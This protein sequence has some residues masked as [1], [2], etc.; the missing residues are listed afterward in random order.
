[1]RGPTCRE[2]GSIH[3]IV[4]SLSTAA[5]AHRAGGQWLILWRYLAASR[6]MLI[7]SPQRSRNPLRR[8][9]GHLH[10]NILNPR[11]CSFKGFGLG[12]SVLPMKSNDGVGRPRCV[13]LDE[14]PGLAFANLEHLRLLHGRDRCL[15]CLQKGLRANPSSTSSRVS[16]RKRAKAL[17]ATPVSVSRMRPPFILRK[18]RTEARSLKETSPDDLYCS[19]LIRKGSLFPGCKP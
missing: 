2:G 14:Q 6:L 10:R 15:L 7:L 16:S 17:N 18:R 3:S 11:L 13:D 12:H 9:G 19:R 4:G 1:M 5:L 8:G